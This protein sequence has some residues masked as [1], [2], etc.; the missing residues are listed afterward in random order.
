MSAAVWQLVEP[1]GE[2]DGWAK[3]RK[4]MRLE[5]SV[6]EPKQQVRMSEKTR[7]GLRRA[8]EM[9]RVRRMPALEE[10]V[11]AIGLQQLLEIVDNTLP[12]GVVKV[13]PFRACA[14]EAEVADMEREIVELC[15]QNRDVRDLAR[16][17][18][19]AGYRKMP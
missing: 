4:G 15:E 2:E 13:E 5:I 3:W 8:T 10:L 12:D 11:E 1:D 18:L 6:T 17:I 14:T 9:D 16:A 19:R 7:D